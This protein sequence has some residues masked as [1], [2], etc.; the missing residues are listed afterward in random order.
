[1]AV[2]SKQEKA[3]KA[4]ELKRE[5]RENKGGSRGGGGDKSGGEGGGGRVGGESGIWGRGAGGGAGDE[6]RGG[7]DVTTS[8][9][10]LGKASAKA[11][12]KAV[13]EARGDI[14]RKSASRAGKA[15]HPGGKAQQALAAQPSAAEKELARQAFFSQNL[16]HTLSAAVAARA[17]SPPRLEPLH[18]VTLNA[19]RGLNRYIPLH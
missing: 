19:L 14:K 6:A 9:R 1:M 3:E 2:Q 16:N 11:A 18:A 12:A 10:R 4:A 13:G 15:G 17:V 7:V 8:G 5:G